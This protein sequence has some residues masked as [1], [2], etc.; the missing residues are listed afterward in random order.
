MPVRGRRDLVA[1]RELT[2]LEQA[3]HL[4]EIPS[5]AHRINQHGLDELVG[6]DQVDGSDGLVRRGR[7]ALRRGAGVRRQHVVELGNVEVAVADQWVAHVAARC[8]L[9]VG[10]PAR[11]IADGIYREPDD[12]AVTLRELGLELREITEL[13][14]TDRREILRMREQ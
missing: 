6:P 8:I 4:V 11:V 9:D 7:S 14:R 1:R 2:R 10:Q 12:L 5:R 3:Q 13:G